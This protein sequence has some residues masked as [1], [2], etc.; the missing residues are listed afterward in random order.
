MP[1]PAAAAASV[2]SE[3]RSPAR[4]ARRENPAAVGGEGEQQEPHGRAAVGRRD[5]RAGTD[6]QHGADAEQDLGRPG[7]ARP[8]PRIDR[9]P[10]SA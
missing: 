7:T 9:P 4:A 3:L 10:P 1:S 5:R 6:E 2:S 8:T